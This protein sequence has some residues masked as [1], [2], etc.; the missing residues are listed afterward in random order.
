MLRRL[1]TRSGLVRKLRE[2]RSSNRRSVRLGVCN[3]EQRLLLTSVMGDFNGDGYDDLAVGVPGEDFNGLENAGAVN[4]IYGGPTN[5]LH[6][7]GDQLWTQDSPGINGVA[8]ADDF[9][10]SSLAVGDFNGDGRDDLAIGV[11]GEDWYDIEDAGAINILYGSPNLGLRSFGDQVFS[12]DSSGIAG[13]AEAGDRFGSALETGD[14]NG[15]GYDDLAIGVPGESINHKENAGAI[16]VIYGGPTKGLHNLGDQFFHQDSSGVDGVAEEGDAFGSTLAAGDFNGDGRDDL[17]IGVPLEDWYDE[18]DAGAINVMYG[19]ANKGIHSF[20]DRVFSQ[21]TTGIT[22]TAED[23]DM[24]AAALASGDFNGDGYSD[25]AIGVPGESLNNLEDAGAVHVIYGGPTTGLHNVGD[26][27]FNQDSSGVKEKVE[28]G[29]QFGYSLVA[30][31]F[32]GNG[33][34]DLAIGVPFEDLNDTENNSPGSGQGGGGFG[35]PSTG[36]LSGSIDACFIPGGCDPFEGDQGLVHVLYGSTNNGVQSF[37]DQIWTQDSNGVNGKAETSDMFGQQ[38]TAG[39]FNGD[40]QMD[41]VVGVPNED[42]NDIVDA[43]ALNL[44]YGSQNNGVRS[45]GDEVFSQ[46]TVGIA[47]VAEAGDRFGIW[48]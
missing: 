42:W 25:V 23:F 38:L 8:E 13:K 19:S 3:L 22:G 12:Q 1:R 44:L 20:G 5:G 17:V 2:N 47:G 21:D 45:F 27:F 14:F 46:D 33:T 35:S 48:I 40:G 26:Q 30:G 7:V 18:V 15:D 41:L 24:F 39:D 31:D 34:D 10:G 28:E 9:F 11:S 29:D 36:P 4:V 37:G 6:N 16:H 43:G 32:N